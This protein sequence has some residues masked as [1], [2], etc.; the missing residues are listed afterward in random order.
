MIGETGAG[1]STLAN[2]MVLTP[3]MLK[4][5]NNKKKGKIQVKEGVT[6]L[7]KTS[8]ASLSCTGIPGVE[9]LGNDIFLVDCPGFGDTDRYEEYP[10]ITSIHLLMKSC[11]SFKIL[12]CLDTAMLAHRG[13]QFL[14][15]VTKLSRLFNDYIRNDNKALERTIQPVFCKGLETLG[16]E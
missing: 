2:A 15:Q 16:D 8:S 4:R 14:A 12:V 5:Q 9:S 11:K 7:F 13:K 3:Q 6:E 10:N 1:K